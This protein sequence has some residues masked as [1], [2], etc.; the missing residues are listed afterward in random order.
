MKTKWASVTHERSDKYMYNNNRSRDGLEQ[1]R[2]Q[3]LAWA[4]GYLR[5]HV[6]QVALRILGPYL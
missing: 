6:Y 3:A 2:T 5:L 1:P 4:L